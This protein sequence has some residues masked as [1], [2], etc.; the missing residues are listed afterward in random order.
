M[1]GNPLGHGHYWNKGPCEVKSISVVPSFVEG[2]FHNLHLYGALH[3]VMH[4]E[5]GVHAL[6]TL[7][8]CVWWA[9]ISTFLNKMALSSTLGRR[10]VEECPTP[11]AF[12]LHIR[13][14]GIFC[15]TMNVRYETKKSVKRMISRG[16]QYVTLHKYFSH[17]S[18]VLYLFPTSPI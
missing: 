13:W 14:F 6:S 11:G 9:I 3:T 15:L 7:W 2:R 16:A 18:S 12:T 1:K 5:W 4:L 10:L 17:P 8:L